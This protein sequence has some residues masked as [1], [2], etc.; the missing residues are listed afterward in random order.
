MRHGRW[1]AALVAALGAAFGA[2]AAG[3]FSTP[4]D[5]ELGICEDTVPSGS[6]GSGGGTPP[7]C[8]PSENAEPVG[9]ECGVFVSSS[10]GDD[11]NEGTKERPVKTLGAALA[12]G[13]GEGKPVYACAETFSEAAIVEVGIDLFG[14]LECAEGW[15]YGGGSV[16]T[17]LTAGAG[18]IPLTLAAGASGAQVADFVIEAADAMADGGSSIAVVVDGASA[19]FAR[20]DV[21]AG[22]G[23]AGKQGETP[24]DPVGPTAPDD[25]AIKG[26]DGG[27]ACSDAVEVNGGLSKENEFCPSGAGGPLGGAGGDGTVNNGGSGEAQTANAQTAQ[28]G[29]GQPA[30]DPM[31]MWSCATGGGV[32]GS[33]GAPGEVGTGASD[34]LSLGNLSI[35]GYSGVAGQPGGPA[36]P[37]QGGGGGGGAKGKTLCAG[38]SGGGG[39]TGGCGGKGG[40]GGQAGG[41]S[42]GIVS[43]GATLS[44]EAVTIR[45][46]QGGEGGEGG[47]GQGGGV[48]GNGGNG[49]QGDANAPATL[50]A[51]NGGAGGQGG[52]GGKGGG[53]RGGHSIGIAHTGAAP[54]LD[55]ATIETGE[56]GGGGIGAD[57]QHDG[58]AGVK[59]DVQVFP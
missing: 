57:A 48:G 17:T 25:T 39:G 6:G 14:G 42:I 46:G 50:K 18:E 27:A 10:Q 34:E 29:A 4:P 37:G 12:K 45:T 1:T 26:N 44:F 2:Q 55:G 41:A 54:A 21:T 35:A 36:A 23:A 49:G 31:N 16:K 5:C 47:D 51:C 30:S 24:S 7:G 3:C 19:A 58:A 28:G 59:T 53:G 15:Q 13:A 43:L 9:D 11:A 52:T 33:N 8:V 32:T 40:L 20:C 38:G 22:N 56:P